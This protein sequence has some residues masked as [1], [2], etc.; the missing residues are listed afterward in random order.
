MSF[1]VPVCSAD[2]TPPSVAQSGLVLR[3]ETGTTTS[4]CPGG[5]RFVE[6]GGVFGGLSYDEGFLLSGAILLV[7]IAGWGAR[8]VIRVIRR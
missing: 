7:W 8:Q 1:Y 4:N 5:F 2:S 6:T 3:F